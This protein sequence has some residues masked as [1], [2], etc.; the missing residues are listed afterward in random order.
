MA[1]ERVYQDG[2]HRFRQCGVLCGYFTPEWGELDE[3]ETDKPVPNGKKISYDKLMMLAK[4]ISSLLSFN[5]FSVISICFYISQISVLYM[6]KP[7]SSLVFFFLKV[8]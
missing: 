3:N 7:F 1:S 6:F 4:T 2:Q 8:K 5:T